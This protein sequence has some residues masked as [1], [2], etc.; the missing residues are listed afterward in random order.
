MLSPT[1]RRSLLITSS[2]DLG[3]LGPRRSRE[4][5][6]ARLPPA[7]HRPQCVYFMCLRVLCTTAK[8]TDEAETGDVCLTFVL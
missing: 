2:L 8:D 4:Q 5:W 7:L 3:L 6:E 1:S